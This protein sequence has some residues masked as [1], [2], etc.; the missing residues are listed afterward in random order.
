MHLAPL[1]SLDLQAGLDHQAQLVPLERPDPLVPLGR[2]VLLAFV[3]RTDPLEDKEKEAPQ[4]QP[5]VQ[6]TRETLGRTDPRVLMGLQ[7]PPEQQD[8]E[9]LWVFLVRGESVECWDFQDQRVLQGNRGLQDLGEIKVLLARSVL[10]VPTDP[11]AIPV[12]MVLLDLMGHQAKLESLVKGE[13][14]GTM[15]QRD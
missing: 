7:V 12:P 5:E 11:V 15:V 10:L 3:E 9:V 13:R 14:E 4:D 1:V 8:R 2:R 6:E